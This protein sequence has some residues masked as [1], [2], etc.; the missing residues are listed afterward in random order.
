MDG[1]QECAQFADGG[2]TL[3]FSISCCLPR[4][5]A[6]INEFVRISVSFI[7]SGTNPKVYSAAASTSL[8]FPFTNLQCIFTFE[9]WSLNNTI[10]PP[11][12]LL[13]LLA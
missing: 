8:P 4:A 12:P 11:L 5:T 9:V 6:V 13:L 2:A 10:R 1:S 3:I 7:K